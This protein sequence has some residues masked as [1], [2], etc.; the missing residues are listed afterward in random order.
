[1]KPNALSYQY[2]FSKIGFT[3]Y[4]LC[5]LSFLFI[6]CSCKT[7]EVVE[8]QEN[9]SNE[10]LY[11]DEIFFVNCSKDRCNTDLTDSLAPIMKE[12]FSDLNFSIEYNDSLTN[13]YNDTIW[14]DTTPPKYFARRK[15]NEK[16][17]MQYPFRNNKLKIVPFLYYNTTRGFST[18]H[19]TYNIYIKVVIF[20]IDDKAVTYQAHSWHSKTIHY[21]PDLDD[22]KKEDIDI[23][24]LMKPI[25]YKALNPYIERSGN[26]K[27]IETD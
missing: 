11:M 27:K 18:A 25:I 23:T 12:A 2:L 6:L 7:Y 24:P 3:F 19:D 5:F 22:F 9:Y 1:M 4:F 13:V 20:I 15:L 10:T 17:M 14:R 26:G 8:Y 21:V 16:Y